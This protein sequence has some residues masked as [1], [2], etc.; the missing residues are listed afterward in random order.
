M[1]LDDFLEKKFNCNTVDF[2]VS[3]LN[4]IPVG[5]VLDVKFSGDR[6][7]TCGDDGTIRIWDGWTGYCVMVLTGHLNSVTSISLRPTPGLHIVI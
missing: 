1:C 3:L 4:I 7:V 5:Q 6:V 2:D